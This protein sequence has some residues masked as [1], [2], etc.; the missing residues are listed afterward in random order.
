MYSYIYC[1]QRLTPPSL[2]L[3]EGDQHRRHCLRRIVAAACTAL[4]YCRTACIASLPLRQW[5]AEYRCR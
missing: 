5:L 4:S 3:L 1:R 2:L